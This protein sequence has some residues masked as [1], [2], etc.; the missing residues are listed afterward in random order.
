[1]ARTTVAAIDCGTNS[2]R[3]LIAQIDGTEKTDLTREMRVVRLGQGVDQSGSLAPEAV[4]RTIAACR[5]YALAIEA[6][7]VDVV[8]FAATSAVRDADNAQ[9]FSDA[10]EAVLG[11]RPRILTGDEEARASFEGA[12]GD[13]ADVLTTV[14]DLG[15]GS[16]EVVQ[17]VG[18]PTF[19]HSFDLGSVRMTERFLQTDPPSVAE[20]TACMAHL[21]A[22]IA[23]KLA[24][25]P[26]TEEIVGVAGTITTIAAHALGLPSYDRELIH[27]ARIHVDDLRAACSSLMQMPVVDR[28]ALPYMHPG[29]ADVIAGGALILDR[30]L[31][32]LPRATDEIVVSEQDILDGIA[33]AAAR[34]GA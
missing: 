6:M 11:V 23:P 5:E 16:T 14:I 10:V 25:L 13:V 28:R 34:E 22:V 21:D 9:E 17:G 19:A 31:E 26:P 15:G 20:V 32:H 3:L 2:I 33:W 12:T 8:S 27:L 7:G 1:M 18:A 30:V 29:R 24:D 4:E